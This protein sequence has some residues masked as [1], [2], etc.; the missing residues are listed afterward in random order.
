MTKRLSEL[1][2]DVED[3]EEVFPHNLVQIAVGKGPNV[4][5]RLANTLMEDWILSEDIVFPY[6]KGLA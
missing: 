3:L 4:A 1:G 5:G 2:V 6:M